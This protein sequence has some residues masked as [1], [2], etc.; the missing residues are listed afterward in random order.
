EITP[1]ASIDDNKLKRSDYTITNQIK[2]VFEN[3]KQGQVY[4]EALTFI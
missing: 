2:E 4:K 1:V 3:L